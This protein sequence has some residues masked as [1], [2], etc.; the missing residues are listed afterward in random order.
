LDEL[1]T[2]VASDNHT[3]HDCSISC[4]MTISHAPAVEANVPEVSIDTVKDVRIGVLGGSGFYGLD[5]LTP[6]CQVWLTANGVTGDDSLDANNI[7]DVSQVYPETPWGFP[8]DRIMVTQTADGHKVAFLARHGKGHQFN[9]TEIPVR[10]NIAA[11][12]RLGCQARVLG[13]DRRRDMA[14]TWECAT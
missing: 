11:L 8:S 10:A 9:P 7:F 3:L 14:N 1:T 6:V 4:N 12:K 5:H 13:S 2:Q